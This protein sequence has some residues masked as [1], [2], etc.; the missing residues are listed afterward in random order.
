MKKILIR[1]GPSHL[2]SPE[3]IKDNDLIPT[4]DPKTERAMLIRNING[5]YAL[6]KAKWTWFDTIQT[7]TPPFK[8]TT[9]DLGKLEGKVYFFEKN[10][11]RKFTIGNN[12]KL[13][14]W[15]NSVMITADLK[16]GI[17]YLEVYNRDQLKAL[18]VESIVAIIQSIAII[19]VQLHPKIT[20]EDSPKLDCLNKE[21]ILFFLVENT[22]VK[23][24][25]KYII[26]KKIILKDDKSSGYLDFDS[27]YML[28]SVGYNELVKN[29]EYS[30]NSKEFK[31]KPNF[32]V[33]NNEWFNYSNNFRKNVSDEDDESKL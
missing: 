9:L 8:Q 24:F 2:P 31:V 18:E 33:C 30:A 22:I 1:K 14:V 16:T 27:C 7:V 29:C 5:H 26:E 20:W 17:M 11:I 13:K 15:Y 12:L 19:Y 3:Q 28:S 21:G 25:F 32:L 23:Y 6:V 10:C 4:L